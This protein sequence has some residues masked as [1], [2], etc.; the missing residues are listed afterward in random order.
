MTYDMTANQYINGM[1]FLTEKG[2]E[3][4]RFA[5]DFELDANSRANL[6]VEIKWRLEKMVNNYDESLDHLFEE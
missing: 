4:L 5:H 6:R 3:N 1:K 2:K